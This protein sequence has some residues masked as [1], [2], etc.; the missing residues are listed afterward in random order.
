VTSQM[1]PLSRCQHL[2]RRPGREPVLF[3]EM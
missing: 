2:H 3:H 1:Q